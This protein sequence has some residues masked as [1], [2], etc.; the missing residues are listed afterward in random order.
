ME[1]IIGA[2]IGAVVALAAV[3]LTALFTRRHEERTWR[4]DQRIA[5]YVAFISATSAVEQWGTAP[6]WAARLKQGQHPTEYKQD[7]QSLDAAMARLNLVVPSA[8]YFDAVNAHDRLMEFIGRSTEAAVPAS[9]F[10]QVAQLMSAKQAAEYDARQKI[11][12]EAYAEMAA[13]AK[14]VHDAW[15]Q[16]RREF[17]DKAA[18]EL[19]QT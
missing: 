16:A 14:Q 5:A 1:T 19:G 18:N 7:L 8:V 17:L 3:F 9:L 12:G 13:D 4:R 15:Q 11:R 6:Q 2:A 10:P